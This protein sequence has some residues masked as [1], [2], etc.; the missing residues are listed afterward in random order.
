MSLP[1][2]V[3]PA[4][5]SDAVLLQQLRGSEESAARMAFSTLFLRHTPQ[6]FAA[7]LRGG[8]AGDPASAEDAV[9]AVM[10]RVWERRRDLPPIDNLG[11]YLIRAAARERLAMRRSEQRTTAREIAVAEDDAVVPGGGSGEAALLEEELRSVLRDAIDA[12]PGRT[13]SLF[14][15]WY[16]SHATYDSVA[17]QLGVSTQAIV[18]ARLRAIAKLRENP[19]LAALVK[20]L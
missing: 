19:R 14:R 16:T 2:P 13:G 18:Q 15:A 17:R 20:N 12:L 4:E 5:L 6:M 11:P 7:V 10:I 3:A 8:G 1:A 9:Q